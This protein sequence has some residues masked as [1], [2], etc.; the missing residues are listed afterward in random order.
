MPISVRRLLCKLTAIALAAVPAGVANASA[1]V[2]GS[3]EGDDQELEDDRPIDRGPLEANDAAE[4]LGRGLALALERM[5]PLSAT[6]LVTSWS[7]SVDPVRRLAV[8]NA[9]EWSFRLVG[10]D[11][12]IDHLARDPDPTIRG[13]AARAAWARRATGGDA[14]VL[15]RLADDPDPQVR[16]LVKAAR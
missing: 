11:V 4:E 14:G 8:A 3:V 9:L 16:E 10:D 2:P 7:L 15:A 5:R 13:A 12:V 6:Q 1:A